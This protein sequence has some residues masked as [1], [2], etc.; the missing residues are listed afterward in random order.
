MQEYFTRAVRAI[1]GLVGDT[2][3]VDIDLLR[4]LDIVE[5]VKRIQE[6]F[7]NANRKFH[8]EDTVIPVM[9]TQIGGGVFT[10]IAGPCSVESEE[11]IIAIAKGRDP[12]IV[13]SGAAVLAEGFEPLAG[14]QCHSLAAPLPEALAK[15]TATLDPASNLPAPL[16]LR[17]PDATPPSR[18]PGQPRTAST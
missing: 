4:A 8:E 13:G 16:Y 2:T 18:L 14:A 10:M 11:Q 6:P 5:D 9:D 12:V 7:K 1:Y 3:A 17:A 15:L